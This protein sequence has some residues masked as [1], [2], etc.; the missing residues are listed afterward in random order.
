[1]KGGC[2]AASSSLSPSGELGPGVAEA[3]KVVIG[4]EHDRGDSQQ[5]G[6]FDDPP[7]QHGLARAR[8]CEDCN[9]TRQQVR[10]EG[11]LA[12][13][14]ALKPAADRDQPASTEGWLRA[15]GSR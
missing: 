2:R 7:Q 15:G 5:G 9:M 4:V 11:H 12:E 10:R 14:A 8:A 6:F 3:R 13:R 1:M